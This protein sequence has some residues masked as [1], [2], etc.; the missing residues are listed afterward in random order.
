MN[1]HRLSSARS[2]LAVAGALALSLTGMVAA[3]AAIPAQPSASVADNTLTILGTGGGDQIS[4]SETVGDPTHVQ[5]DLG[6]GTQLQAFDRSTFAGVSVFLR[7]GDDQFTVFRGG[8]TIETLPVS[9]DGGAGNDLITAG[10]ADDVVNGGSGDDT[11]N[12]GDGYDVVL[13][14]GGAD[15]VD[16]QRGNDTELLGGGA[17]VAVWNPGEGN[18][19]VIGGSG[20]DTMLFH[21]SNANETMQLGASGTHAI[22]SRNVA[23]IRMDLDEIE[24]FH[25]DVLGG[26]DDVTVGDLTGTDIGTTEVNLLSQGVVDGAA[27]KVTVVGTNRAD[28]VAVDAAAGVVAATGL[29][30]DVA[31][32]GAE[33]LDQLQVNTLGGNDTVTVSAAAQTV[34]PVSFDLGIGQR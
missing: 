10:P 24:T 3:N 21:G 16:G 11:L 17:D 6:N 4:I 13:G 20:Q 33:Q 15:L 25:V 27:D 14:G 34:L 9:V 19:T 23:A 8:A 7:G 28:H 22:F 1:K 12:G 26:T 30:S 29:H 31:L 2:G 18:D 5:V 32:T